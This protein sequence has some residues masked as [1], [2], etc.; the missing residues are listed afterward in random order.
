VKK[1]KNK[2][3]GYWQ[4]VD[5]A[6]AEAQK[7]LKTEGWDVLPGQDSLNEHGYASLGAAIVKHHGGFPEFRESLGQ[8]NGRIAN[9]SWR[10]E[11]FAVQQAKE[12]MEK[13]GWETLPAYKILKSKGYSSL[14]AA[15]TKYHNGFHD[16]RIVLGEQPARAKHGLLKNLDYALERAQEIM[17]KEGWDELPTSSVL[18]ENGYSA[19]NTAICNFH[20]G[21]S[22]FRESLGQTPYLRRIGLWK[23]EQFAITQARAIM[24]EQGLDQFPGQKQLYALGRSD[25]ANAIRR[26][27]GGLTHFRKL[28]AERNGSPSEKEQLEGILRAY[29]EEK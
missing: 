10:D 25:I 21:F 26:Y 28:L 12:S 5:N 23:D 20:G 3:R 17:E 11:K 14:G 6:V 29:V 2:P 9:G 16:F 22:K 19:F 1:T 8:K 7:M 4:N 13:E 15:I 18:Q 27:H 24:D